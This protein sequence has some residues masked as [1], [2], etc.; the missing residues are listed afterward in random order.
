MKT[1]LRLSLKKSNGLSREGH[2]RDR[3]SLNYRSFMFGKLPPPGL[4]G[5]ML[6]Y[7]MDVCMYVCMFNTVQAISLPDSIWHLPPS[8]SCFQRSDS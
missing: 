8:I 5:S 6:W 2:G 1:L 3:L 7:G 4:P